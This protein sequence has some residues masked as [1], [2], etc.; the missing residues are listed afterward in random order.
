MSCDEGHMSHEKGKQLNYKKTT[1]CNHTV[2]VR[3]MH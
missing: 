2:A 1:L 3:K